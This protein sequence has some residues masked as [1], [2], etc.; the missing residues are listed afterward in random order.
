MRIEIDARG[1]VAPEPFERVV[2]ALEG[3]APGDEIVL[4]LYRE[5]YPLYDMLVRNGYRY[6]TEHDEDGTVRVRIT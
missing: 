1:M 3:F 2:E 5:P 6:S 4:L